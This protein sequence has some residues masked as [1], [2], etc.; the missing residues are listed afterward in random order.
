MAKKLIK[1]TSFADLDKQSKTNFADWLYEIYH[2]EYVQNKINPDEPEVF[3]LVIQKM[4]EKVKSERISIPDK[5]VQ[6]YCNRR[7]FAFRNA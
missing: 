2:E 6:V 4:I 5:Q 3:S 7:K 1:V